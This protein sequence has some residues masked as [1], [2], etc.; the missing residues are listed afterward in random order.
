MRL[1][2]LLSPL[3]FALVSPF[4]AWGSDWSAYLGGPA[5]MSA[6]LETAITPLNATTLRPVWHWTPPP[7]TGSQPA[8]QLFA[9]PTVAHGAIYV[10]SNTGVF[11]A[12]SETTGARLWS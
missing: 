11:F 7:A 12:R 1:R 4:A 6:S 5:H 9:S 2:L 8:A 3:L 10:G